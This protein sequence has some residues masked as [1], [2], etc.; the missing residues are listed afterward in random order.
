M[1][2]WKVAAPNLIHIIACQAVFGSE[3][4]KLLPII[5]AHATIIGAKPEI[6]FPILNDGPH[7]IARQTV[8]NGENGKGVAILDWRPYFL[9][10]SQFYNILFLNSSCGHKVVETVLLQILKQE[11]LSLKPCLFRARRTHWVCNRLKTSAWDMAIRFSYMAKK[12]L[13]Q[14]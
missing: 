5:T 3:G 11:T 6:P 1:D 4:G 10:N 12:S 8:S 9:I 7:L 13:N 14:Q 2:Q